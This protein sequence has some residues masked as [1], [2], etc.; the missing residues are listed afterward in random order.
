[1]FAFF[2]FVRGYLQGADEIQFVKM[3]LYVLVATCIFYSSITIFMSELLFFDF[4]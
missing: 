2:I 4:I 1:M 3:R